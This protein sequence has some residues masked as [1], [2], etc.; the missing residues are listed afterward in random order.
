MVGVLISV[1]KYLS[2]ARVYPGLP[3]VAIMIRVTL[4]RYLSSWTSAKK[5]IILTCEEKITFD[6][7]S[8]S[9]PVFRI[10]MTGI[11]I[12]HGLLQLFSLASVECLGVTPPPNYAFSQPV[13]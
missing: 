3:P 1:K 10:E 7:V 12:K 2:L 13:W 6:G 11:L 8:E 5:K 9:F 4:E